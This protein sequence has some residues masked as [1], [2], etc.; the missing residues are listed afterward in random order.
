MKAAVAA[1]MVLA[2]RARPF[3][4][5]GVGEWTR[6][7]M[8]ESVVSMPSKKVASAGGVVGGADGSKYRGLSTALRSGRDDGVG[9]GLKD[10]GRRVG[11][12]GVAGPSASRCALR[13]G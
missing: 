13:S 12:E 6:V 11:E 8:P 3:W 7:A 10:T 4:R 2:M 1:A 5:A 9:L